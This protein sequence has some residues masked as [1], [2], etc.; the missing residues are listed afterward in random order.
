ML[1]VGDLERSTAWYRDVLG[2]QVL[3]TRDNAEYQY[4]LGFVGYGPEEVRRWG[5]GLVVGGMGVWVLGFWWAAR[6]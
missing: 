3:R 2:M 1:R 4:T 6:L 5:V